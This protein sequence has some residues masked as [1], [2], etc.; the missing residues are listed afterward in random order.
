[1]TQTIQLP[2]VKQFKELI[3]CCR[4]DWNKDKKGYDI[5]GPNGNSIFLPALGFKFNKENR[6]SIFLPAL[7][8]KFNK[9]NEVRIGGPHGFYW[10]STEDSSSEGYYLY[11]G[12]G[13]LYTNSRSKSYLYFPVRLVQTPGTD[14]KIDNFVDLGLP[15]GTLWAKNNASKEYMNWDDAMDFIHKLNEIDNKKTTN[16]KIM[17]Y[18]RPTR[19]KGEE[20][21][22]NMYDE[23]TRW[24]IITI[25]AVLALFIL[26]SR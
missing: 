3:N 23:F 21:E 14:S 19:Y 10:S 12:S 26:S 1:M 18:I 9:E 20:S 24:V 13:G 16:T 17:T 5:I 15:S 6:N 11:F 22:T 7:E 8:F 4:C 2:T 25:I